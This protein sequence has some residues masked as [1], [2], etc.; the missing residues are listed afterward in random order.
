MAALF[1]PPDSL[2]KIQQPA[3]AQARIDIL[4][5]HVENKIVGPRRAPDEE[6]EQDRPAPV[7]IFEEKQQAADHGDADKKPGLE[8]HPAWVFQVGHVRG[9]INFFS[10]AKAF[11]S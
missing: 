11:I 6:Q 3:V 9:M 4:L 2:Q 8:V 1:R 5:Q 10:K 7:R